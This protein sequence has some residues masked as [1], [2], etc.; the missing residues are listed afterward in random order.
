LH[1]CTCGTS[2]LLGLTSTDR[3]SVDVEACMRNGKGG[4]GERV[5]LRLTTGDVARLFGVNAATVSRWYRDGRFP[6]QGDLPGWVRFWRLTTR[7]P[8]A[9]WPTREQ[10]REHPCP[11]CGAAAST[12]CL[13]TRGQRRSSLHRE[14]WLVAAG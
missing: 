10:A 13:G 12:P 14:R 2:V 11:T 3:R 7:D 4:R 9:G 5:L 8:S 6:A 1:V